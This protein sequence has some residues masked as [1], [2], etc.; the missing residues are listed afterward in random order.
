MPDNDGFKSSFDLTGLNKI[1][2]LFKGG[3]NNRFDNISNL[4]NS[5][6]KDGIYESIAEQVKQRNDSQ[7]KEYATRNV[8]PFSTFAN[9]HST[10]LAPITNPIA[11]R[12]YPTAPAIAAPHNPLVRYGTGAITPNLEPFPR[13]ATGGGGARIINT[14]V[15]SPT[16]EPLP[17][18]FGQRALPPGTGGAI[19]AK[20]DCCGEILLALQKITDILSD[21]QDMLSNFS[22]HKG[23]G[24]GHFDRVQLPK[25][26]KADAG[27]IFGDIAKVGI[28][29]LLASL[30]IGAIGRGPLAQAG[31]NITR[32]LEG[33]AKT[34]NNFNK[35]I[36]SASRSAGKNLRP[37]DVLNK[38]EL[39]SYDNAAQQ[40]ERGT[41]GI[42]GILKRGLGSVGRGLTATA[43]VGQAA[44]SGYDAFK[45]FQDK[46]A[47]KDKE[48]G[49]D[50][51]RGGRHLEQFGAAFLP[52]I[53]GKIG[54]AAGLGE[55]FG[56][57][58]LGGLLK[59]AN[60]L[61]AVG[62]GGAELGLELAG[63]DKE[64]ERIKADASLSPAERTKQINEISS[65]TNKS[66]SE[67]VG[68]TAG[69]LVGGGIGAA[70]G[71]I[72]PGA[73]TVLG[74]VLGSTVGGVAGAALGAF[75]GNLGLG[76]K[77][78]GLAHGIG[79]VLAPI[80][81]F[82]GE[83][84]KA[85]EPF[86]KLAMSV[87]KFDAAGLQHGFKDLTVGLDDF[88][89]GLDLVLGFIAHV[90]QTIAASPLGKL[91]GGAAEWAGGG[92][93]NAVGNAVANAGKG[94]DALSKKLDAETAVIN[95]ADAPTAHKT[96]VNMHTMLAQKAQ[97]VN[98]SNVQTAR[99]GTNNQNSTVVNI[100]NPVIK[101]IADKKDIANYVK[102]AMGQVA[103]QNSA[104]SYSNTNP[105]QSQANF[106][107]GLSFNGL[108][109]FF[110]S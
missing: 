36:R 27:N 16:G 49:Y 72:V 30:G 29:G 103:A 98:A 23:G 52:S 76:D 70:I 44:E 60:P 31:L 91:V 54:G 26:E 13:T 32:A 65:R 58:G 1:A 59:G 39:E 35:R 101:D 42:S 107:P 110:N 20:K 64:I 109:S 43:F 47:G 82:G 105:I 22:G 25:D 37:E 6:A 87:A 68:G 3:V 2:G 67:I 33:P 12:L 69:S 45:Y 106:N 10:A 48:A 97:E 41:G 94:A 83:V 77:L 8:T 73:G 63:K 24:R 84:E 19:A 95:G 75:G 56:K 53:I 99:A 66:A 80:G 50:L 90:A 28:A 86:M 7:Y 51:E 34:F 85:A 5:I 55:L 21:I 88:K 38:S 46:S 102:N 74:G 71:S 81:K 100:N 57:I 104:D 96:A 93:A 15:T 78:E 61:A 17:G 4:G 14:T 79:S 11:E 108:P 18:G 40:I 89:K 62:V 92:I 9:T